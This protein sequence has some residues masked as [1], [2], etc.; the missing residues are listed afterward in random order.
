MYSLTMTLSKNK[1][2]VLL[3]LALQFISA[4]SMSMVYSLAPTIAAA[5]QMPASNAPFLN[6]GFVSAGL[7]SPVFGVWADKQGTKKVLIIGSLIFTLGHGLGAISN[8]IGI[9]FT[10]RLLVGLGYSAILGLTVS[11]LSKLL[12]HDRMGS[13]SAYLKLAF[14]LGVFVAPIMAATV[15]QWLGFQ[16]LYVC[17]TVISV[18]LSIGLILI[19]DVRIKH[20]DH[21][22]MEE[23]KTLFRNKSF[24]YFMGVS[25][26]TSLPGVLFFNFLSVYLNELG[27]AQSMISAVYSLA[28]MGTIASAFVILWLNQR[29]GMIRLFRY[30][31]YLT[32]FGLLP[33]LFFNPILLFIATAVFALGY[34]TIVGLINPV[35]AMEY[36]R[37][38]GTVIMMISLLGA[39]YGTL[40]NVFGPALYGSLG[41]PGLMVIGIAGTL[42]GTLSLQRAL[43]RV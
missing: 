6:I 40:T 21:V 24:W 35:L 23:V 15:V 42:L 31:L 32:L 4:L 26:A 38:S 20:G 28:G 22:T 3:L 9:Y 13:V 17:F 37:H 29:F 39:V 11:Y 34:D 14:A 16:S 36:P 1:L 7:L 19:P 25:L 10:A 30:G 33:M 12:H 41:F 5:F 2:T 18:F 8:S 27:Y 43:K